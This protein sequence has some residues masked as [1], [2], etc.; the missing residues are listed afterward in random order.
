MIMLSLNLILVTIFVSISLFVL[1]M[2]SYLQWL[3]L[4]PEYQVSQRLLK[5]TQG[6]DSKSMEIPFVIRDDQLSRIPTLNRLLQKLHVSKNLQRMLDQADLKMRVGELIL[7]I[8]ISGSIGFLISAPLEIPILSVL[9]VAMLSY[10]PMYYVNRRR[11]NRLK[12]FT[13]QFPDA[14][15]MMTSALRAGHG[16]GR[17]L[18]LVAT[19]IPDPLGTEFRKTFEENNLGLPTREALINLTRRIDSVDLKLFATAVIIQRES[20]GDLTEVLENISH[21][22]RERFRL[23]GQIRIYTTQGRITTW[24]LGSLP[25]ALAIIISMFDADYISLLFTE[26]LG[27]I[28]VAVAIIL[29]L[30]GFWV[31]RKIVKMKVQ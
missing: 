6:L 15:D 11:K 30:L 29:Q 8:L 27:Q 19:E 14:L 13:Q 26:P 23:L 1:A 18:Q 24:I 5:F 25:I 2:Y 22:I 9:L 17:A 12:L 7:L 3:F 28:M 31:I 20:G 16:F 10:I 4:G 21:T